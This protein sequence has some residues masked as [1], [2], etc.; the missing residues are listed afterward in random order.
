MI[1]DYFEK[2]FY[3]N[4]EKREDRKNLFEKRIAKFNLNIE[5]FNA[6]TLPDYQET[7][8]YFKN[9]P[10]RNQKIAC[11]LS[12]LTII[13]TAKQFG[14]RNVLI[15][16]DDCV[17]VDDFDKKIV[18]YINE[19]KNKDWYLFYMGGE[20]NAE[21]K[22]VG[23]YLYKCENGGFYGTHAYAINHTFYDEILKTNPFNQETIDV[24]YLNNRYNNK[25]YLTKELLVYQDDDL[26]SDLWGQ[27]IKRTNTYESAYKKY[28]I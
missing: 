23:D 28:V 1:F 14:W 3:I 12:H 7:N 16:E 22:K 24:I 5:R 20:P 9:S 17:F 13:N 21:C 8:P 4:L 2:A 18:P 19:L 15:F 6:I 27:V 25:Y 11:S 26:Y 10:Q